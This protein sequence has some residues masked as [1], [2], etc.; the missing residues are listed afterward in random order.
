MS[1][2]M[3]TIDRSTHLKILIVGSTAAMI[4]V[5]IAANARPGTSPGPTATT[6]PAVSVTPPPRRQIEPP[7]KLHPIALAYSRPADDTNG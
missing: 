6:A 1:A 5:G 2:S 4:V 3:Y 7:R